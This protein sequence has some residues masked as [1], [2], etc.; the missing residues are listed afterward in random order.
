MRIVKGNFMQITTELLVQ[1]QANDRRAQRDLYE[2][3]FKMHIAH[4]YS[5]MGNEEDA[6]AILNA[7]FMKVCRNIDTVKDNVAVFFSWSRKIVLNCVLDEF[8]KTKRIKEHQ[9]NKEFE[10]ELE[11]TDSSYQNSGMEHLMEEDI[12][13]L[14]ARLPDAQRKAFML[15]ALEGYAHKEIAKLMHINE[16]TSKWL[17]FEARKTLRNMIEKLNGSLNEQKMVI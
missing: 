15:F 11:Q 14:I 2:H 6:R 5:Y 4:C 17:V 12:K 16:G 7:G 3:F 10:Y 9:V 8:R 1:C 13:G